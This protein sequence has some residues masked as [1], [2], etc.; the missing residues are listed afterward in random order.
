M[1]RLLGAL[2]LGI[3]ILLSSVSSDAVTPRSVVGSQGECIIGLGTCGV[4]FP[5]SGAIICDGTGANL[6]CPQLFSP[7]FADESGLRFYGV[8]NRTNPP[9]YIVSIDGGVTWGLLTTQPYTG[10]VDN[11]GATIAVSSSGV[12][13]APANQGANNCIFRI[14]IDKGVSWSTAYTDTSATD[15]CGL[16]FGAPVANNARCAQLSGY[17]AVI[18]PAGG[19]A[20]NFTTYYSND[21]GINWTKGSPTDSVVSSDQLQIKLDNS[22]VDGVVGVG[23]MSNGNGPVYK[24]GDV[25]REGTGYAWAGARCFGSVMMSATQ[26]ICGPD[27][28]ARTVYQ[29][30]Q[31]GGG[32]AVLNNTFTLADAPLFGNSPNFHVEA[33]SSSIAYLFG[34]NLAGTKIN[35]YITTDAFVSTMLLVQLT[36]TT[37]LLACYGES[38]KW[39]GNIYFTCGGSGANA[40]LGRL[41]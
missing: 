25:F 10:A 28:A 34:R 17:C 26:L 8:T 20:F 7:D 22:G 19:G 30:F 33:Y 36:P 41:Q 6:D 13:I 24:L 1:K 3:G 5:T 15:N 38:H 2:V 23:Q 4:V 18:N 12:I 16:A 40:F 32:L 21:N 11:L 14:S 39:G 29:N 27:N 37:A 9:R 35:V 31:V